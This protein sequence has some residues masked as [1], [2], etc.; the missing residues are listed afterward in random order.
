MPTTCDGAARGIGALLALNFFMADMQAGIGPFLGVFLLAHHWNNA[1]IGTMMT[2]GGLAGMIMTVPAGALVDYT[3]RKRQLVAV[4]GVCTICGSALL[5]VS[6][7][8]WVV[9]SSQI[10]TAIAGAAIGPAVAGM[11]LGM[12]RQA[13][14]DRQNGRNQACNHA[15]NLGGAALSG[16]LGWQF[17]FGAIIV[18]AACFGIASIVAVFRIPANAIDHRAARGSRDAAAGDISSWRVLVTCRPLL[19]LAVALLFFH[20]GNGAMLPLF[21]MAMASAHQGNPAALVAGT[22]VV[23]QAVMIGM[24]LIAL[25]MAQRQALWLAMLL[26]FLALPIR[27]VLAA[28]LIVGWGVFPV[29]I[30]DGVGAGLQS[31]AVP[32]FVAHILNGT[33]RV[34]AGQ[35][36]VM[37]IQALGASLSPALGGFVA[38]RLGYSSSFLTLGCMA[39]VSIGIWITGGSLVRRASGVRP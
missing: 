37:T 14:F 38:D 20:L 6:Q 22:I 8:V 25:R 16:L 1:A 24:S 35:G 29:Q 18:L 30:L 7:S 10:L 13:G 28:H 9:G 39:L 31:V 27:G 12:V 23:A 33:G 5:L 15:G 17:G 36:A 26:S 2:L 32:A 21:G 34:N 19:V 11:T 3:R 4:S